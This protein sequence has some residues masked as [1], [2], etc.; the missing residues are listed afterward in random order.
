MFD[1]IKILLYNHTKS[2]RSTAKLNKY[3]L[4]TGAAGGLGKAFTMEF[5]KRKHNLL[6]TDVSEE[7][8][9]I[10]EN[11]INIFDEEIDVKTFACDLTNIKMRNNLFN[12]IMKNDI[13][14][15]VAVNVAGLDFEGLIENLSSENVAVMCRLNL[16]STYD[17]NRFIMTNSKAEK[18]YIINTASLGG[19]YPMPFKALYSASKSAV[20]Q[21]SLALR[22][23]AKGRGNVLVLCP[24]GLR[25]TPELCRKIDSQG[26][27]GRI[28]TIDIEKVAKRT[29]RKVYRRRAVFIPGYINRIILGLSSVLPKTLRAK[30]IYKR[31]STRKVS[32]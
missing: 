26:F 22:E 5:V 13:E 31:W 6:L 32:V 4:I 29:M 9:K 25:T 1:I 20:I 7:R 2:E 19:F 16:E 30:I 8:L 21:F 12:F 18:F 3:T 10:L 15:N 28:T 23:E 17:I 27:M 11:Y 14:I 24:A